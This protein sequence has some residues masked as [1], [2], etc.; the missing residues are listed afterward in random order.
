[1]GNM[2]RLHRIDTPGYPRHLGVRAVNG[3]DCFCDDRDRNVYLGYLREA[4]GRGGCALNAY[5]LMS[6]HVHLLVT[7]DRPG[8]VAA[9]MQSVGTR[10]ARYFNAARDRTG[11]LFAG[12]YWASLIHTGQYFLSAMRYIELNPVRARLVGEAAAYPWSSHRHN[13][14]LER[15]PELT[16]HG[17]YLGLQHSPEGRARV[18]ADF[19]LQGIEDDELKSLRKHFRRSQPLGPPSNPVREPGS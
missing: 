17:E 16:F 4:I 12:R 13:V 18:W 10:Y 15:R 7:P 2:G 1:M 5:V 6:N 11:P 14:G 3:M 19:V 8:V 9:M